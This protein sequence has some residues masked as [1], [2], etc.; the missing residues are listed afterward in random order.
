MRRMSELG[1]ADMRAQLRDFRF[2]AVADVVPTGS[3]HYPKLSPSCRCAAEKCHELAPT[4]VLPP[5]ANGLH[6]N[7]SNKCLDRRNGA[8][9]LKTPMSLV[10]H[11]LT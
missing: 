1:C 11:V 9:P 3:C 10:G 2:A 6:P 5:R 7:G 4:H 8:F